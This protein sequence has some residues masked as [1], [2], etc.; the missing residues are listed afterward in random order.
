MTEADMETPKEKSTFARMLP[1][2]LISLAALVVLYL[3]VDL[4]DL[5]R[6]LALADYRWLPVVTLLFLGTLASRA[7]AWRTI[8]EERAN[9]SDAFLV[10]NQGYLLNNILPFR[11]G[12][13]GRA[14]L[15][16]RI[17][18]L[19]F[20]RVLPTVVV[21]RVFDLG[22]AAGLLLGSLPFVVEA[23][24]A[25]SAALAA[26]V[27]VVIGF[28]ALFVLAV[29]PKW[30]LDI[31]Q[32]LTR[33]WPKLQTWLAEKVQSFLLGL[34]ALQDPVRFVR[35]AFWMGMAWFFNLAWYYVLLRTFAPQATFLWVI[36]AISVS[37]LGVALPSSPAYVGILE[38]AMVASLALFGVDPALS[39]A[40][41]LVA[42]VLYIVVTGVIGVFAF[43]RQGQS[44]AS[45]YRQLL[46]RTEDVESQA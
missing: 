2:L 8:L 46:A 12:E 37:S 4:N 18:K 38:G 39:L 40:F 35:V 28:A 41:T 1:G 19:G 31:L 44:L 33:P 45:V 32:V 20:W 16:G 43:G 22:V 36:F 15:L 13:L 42:H 24:W 29:R 21:E 3:L 17:T 26:G 7:K 10:L 9:Y 11:L 30:A 23:P 5:Q 34:A 25:R 14:L 27:V 6:A